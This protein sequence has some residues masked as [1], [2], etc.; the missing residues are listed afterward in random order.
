MSQENVVEPVGQFGRPRGVLGRLAGWLMALTNRPLNR[1]AVEVLEVRPGDHILEIGF[2]P[3]HLIQLLAERATEGFVA[4]I[5][6]SE[7]MVEQAA[8]RNR[9]TVRQ[10]RVELCQGSVSSL[11][12]EDGRFDKVVAVN[13]FQFWP[14]PEND[15]REVRRVLKPGGTLVLGLRLKNPARRFLGGLGHTGDEVAAIGTLLAEAGFT[16]ISTRG[17][18]QGQE[19]VAYLVAARPLTG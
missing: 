2:G 10:G 4:G 13:T 12:Y 6:L 18:Q 15:L 14:D 8:R 17:Y 11:P 5:D 7:V 16:G 3:G 9:R 1:W 19:R